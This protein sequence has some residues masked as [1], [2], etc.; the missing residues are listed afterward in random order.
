MRKTWF[1]SCLILLSVFWCL[2]I[3]GQQLSS[4]VKDGVIRVKLEPAV[5]Q[6]LGNTPKT[7][8]GIV[9]TGIQPLDKINKDIKAVEMKRVFPYAPKFEERMRKHGLHLWYEISYDAKLTPEQAAD[10]YK[11]ISGIKIAEIVRVQDLPKY[12]SVPANLPSGPRTR[13]RRTVQR[14]GTGKSMALS[15]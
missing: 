7:R 9:S 5:A 8:G 13:A 10:K 2:P 11:G 12:K 4:Y 3:Y 14:S 15:Q 6:Q 1:L